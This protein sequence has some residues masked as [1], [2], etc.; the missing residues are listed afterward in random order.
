MP[1]STA[2][3]APKR[4][5]AP[6]RK[7][8]PEAAKAAI[9]KAS[10]DEFTERGYDGARVD[11]IARRAGFNKRML[12]HYFGGKDDLYLAVL[13][14]E[15]A[16]IRSAE[17][18][19]DLGQRDP[20]D[21]IR[22]LTLFTWH[23]FIDH[24]EFLSLLGTENLQ[25]ARFL[26]RSNRV[27]SLNSPL[28]GQLDAVIR[29]GTKAGQFRAGLDALDVYLSISG[30]CFFYLGN[31]WTLSTVFGRDLMQSDALA[32]WGDHVVDVMLGYVRR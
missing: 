8:D 6:I 17:A 28:L 16:S 30:Q 29:R 9:F 2:R 24:P 23:Y 11:A 19:L 12:Y 13:E 26:K 25:R 31:K 7:R 14:Y 10:V 5:A 32:N 1:A 27:V 18:E 22:E 15:Y 20:L 3:A 21:A 4:E